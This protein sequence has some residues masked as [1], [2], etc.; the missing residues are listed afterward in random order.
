MEKKR[1]YGI[2]LLR[3]VAMCGVVNLHILSHGGV[4]SQ[5]SAEGGYKSTLLWF[6]EIVFCC[7]VN[8][9]AI[10]TGYVNFSEEEK[11]FKYSKYI[12]VWLP[13]F[14]YSFG[15]TVILFF[16]K[17]GLISWNQLLA[18][19]APVLSDEYW[20]FTAYTFVFMLIPWL[21]KWIREMEKKEMTRLTIILL[22]LSSVCPF[23]SGNVN[24]F[25]LQGG[26]SALWIGVL[27]IVGAWMKKC[28]RLKRL[29]AKWLLIV[30][31]F[32]LIVTWVFWV[33][34]PYDELKNV[35]VSYLNPIICVYSVLMV[36]IFSRVKCSE[37]VNKW[38]R[39]WAPAAFGVYLIHEHPLIRDGIM[40]GRFVWIVEKNIYMTPVYILGSALVIFCIC[41]VIERIRISVFLL[42]KNLLNKNN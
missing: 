35:L 9:Y 14:T 5:I 19:M 12:Y 8:V 15:I 27:Y 36:E 31:V 39:F 16:L 10:I 28:Q 22:G 23:L 41:L 4:L 17:P 42:L 20:Y 33:L 26:Y 1:N 11:P 24:L 18:S 29:S 34:S 37:K 30:G 13:V 3:L 7:A 38:I 21:N 40:R 6:V 32:C 2:D 25:Q